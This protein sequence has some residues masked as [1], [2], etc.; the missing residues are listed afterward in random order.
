MNDVIIYYRYL[1]KIVV[2]ALVCKTNK[3]REVLN[4][5]C[6]SLSSF[7]QTI[8]GSNL[9]ETNNYFYDIYVKNYMQ[10]K[11]YCNM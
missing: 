11:S 5:H 8:T 4:K 3:K 9:I 1:I 7:M 6:L 2:K 10:Y